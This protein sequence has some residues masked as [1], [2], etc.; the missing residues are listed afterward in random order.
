MARFVFAL[1][2]AL[3]ALVTG[4]LSG[5]C[6]PATDVAM[7]AMVVAVLLAAAWLDPKARVG[8]GFEPAL[9]AWLA[10]VFV[11]AA[12]APCPLRSLHLAAQCAAAVALFYLV[13]S[14]PRDSLI[15]VMAAVASLAALFGLGA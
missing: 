9:L 14:G 13:L 5:L 11:C 15:P 6:R 3:T 10:L 2:Y 7:T 1:F 12:F 8:R 4:T